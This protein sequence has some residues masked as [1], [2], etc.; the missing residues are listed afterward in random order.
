MVVEITHIYFKSN[1]F[2]INLDSYGFCLDESNQ[3]NTLHFRVTLST[4]PKLAINH[5]SELFPDEKTL[6]DKANLNI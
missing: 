1:I 2:A 6:E 4:N 3:Y 5:I